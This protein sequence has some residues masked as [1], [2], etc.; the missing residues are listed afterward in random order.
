MAL[1]R[2]TTDNVAC[3]VIDFKGAEGWSSAAEP[4]K[5]GG[6]W[7]GGLFGKK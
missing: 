6:G 2:Y 5:G 7:L 4:Q 1:K 3:T